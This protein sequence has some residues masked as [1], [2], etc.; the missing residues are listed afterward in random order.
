MSQVADPAVLT[1]EEAAAY[2]RLPA[3][4]LARQAAQGSIP[5]RQVDAEWRFLQS[6]LDDW[7]G[8]RDTRRALLRHAGALAD[9]ATLGEIRADVYRQ[10]GRPEADPDP[11][12]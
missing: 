2:L 12:P 8:S 1:L 4:T 10:R 7:L 6:A 5:G 9:D 11:G 3:E